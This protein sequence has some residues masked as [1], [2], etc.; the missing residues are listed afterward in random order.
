[1]LVQISIATHRLLQIEVITKRAVFTTSTRDKHIANKN[2]CY[3]KIILSTAF[4]FET[5]TP[6]PGSLKD[7]PGCPVYDFAFHCSTDSIPSSLLI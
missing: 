1:L 6:T 4:D 5:I 3:A 2:V 7:R